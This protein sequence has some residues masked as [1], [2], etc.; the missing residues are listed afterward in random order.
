[1][2][3]I[4]SESLGTLA[5][6]SGNVNDWSS[7]SLQESLNG[8]YLSGS[9]LGS[10]KGITTSTNDMIETVT[11][12][13]GGLSNGS[14][15]TAT[16]YNAE[17]GTTVYS[18]RPTT[19]PGKIALM[20]PSDYGYATS[21]GSTGRDTCLSY[22]LYNWINYSDCYNN[23]WL[24]NGSNQW[25]LTPYSSDSRYVFY[26]TSAGYVNNRRASY[27]YGVRPSVYLTSEVRISGGD[28]TAN[29]AYTLEV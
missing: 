13:L 1:M 11:W 9:N 18:G 15:T 25:T 5:W 2:K 12:K 4:R 14:N 22:T 10:G 23:D 19:W 28:G 8:S 7:A 29:N 17:R 24:Y 16:F 20:Y 3:L 26:V 21:G 27:S 6:D